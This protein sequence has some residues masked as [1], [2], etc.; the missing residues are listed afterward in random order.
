M[1][2][3]GDY[4]KAYLHI[5]HNMAIQQKQPNNKQQTLRPAVRI[6]WSKIYLFD[7]K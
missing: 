6:T 7:N 4:S 2:Y 1:L 5:Y 3:I